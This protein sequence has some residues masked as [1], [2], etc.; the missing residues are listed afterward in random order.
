MQVNGQVVIEAGWF[1]EGVCLEQGYRS[2]VRKD[3]IGS[4]V[5]YQ[6]L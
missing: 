3:Y 1:F 5:I 2:A 6:I 4:A